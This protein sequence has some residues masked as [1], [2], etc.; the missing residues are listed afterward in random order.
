MF[1]GLHS[2]R[3]N[4]V[5]YKEND[6][7][8]FFYNLQQITMNKVDDM[9]PCNP[10]ISMHDSSAQVSR[11]KEVDIYNINSTQCTDELDKH[12]VL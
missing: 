8:F 7:F 6:G 10:H 5:W 2:V 12:V 1:D 9:A 11:T 4:S 3:I